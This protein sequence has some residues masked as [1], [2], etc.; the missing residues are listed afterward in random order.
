MLPISH[1]GCVNPMCFDLFE[2]FGL[3][4]YFFVLRQ[5]GFELVH[6]LPQPTECGDYR[7][8]PLCPALLV[9]IAEKSGFFSVSSQSFPRG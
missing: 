9:L 5:I 8:V 3:F 1:I 6:F 7:C 4:V 2:F